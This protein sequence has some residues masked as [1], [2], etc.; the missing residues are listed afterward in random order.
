MEEINALRNMG[1]Y[2]DGAKDAVEIAKED[3]RHFE[4]QT[5]NSRPSQYISPWK[6]RKQVN[7]M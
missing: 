1:T 5:P 2:T 6:T 4:K 7:Y 3:T